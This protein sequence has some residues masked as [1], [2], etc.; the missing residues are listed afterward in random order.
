MYDSEN[1]VVIWIDDDIVITK[2]NNFLKKYI[3]IMIENDAHF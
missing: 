3:D 2:N 1:D